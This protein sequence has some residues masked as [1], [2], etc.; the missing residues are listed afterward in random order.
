MEVDR[1]AEHRDLNED[2]GDSEGEE[3]MQKQRH[4]PPGTT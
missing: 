4:V 1:G 2:G 3:K